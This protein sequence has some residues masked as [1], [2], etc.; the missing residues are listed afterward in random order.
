MQIHTSK[1]FPLAR[2]TI[3]RKKYEYMEV[4]SLNRPGGNRI[5]NEMTK[6]YYIKLILHW[7]FAVKRDNIQKYNMYMCLNNL[8]EYLGRI[9]L[10]NFIDA[11]DSEN[12]E[13]VL[14][15]LSRLRLADID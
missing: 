11:I 5:P 8:S 12:F 15:N 4:D 9:D 2:F 14:K 6:H 3:T 7:R 1:Y 13:F 10:Y